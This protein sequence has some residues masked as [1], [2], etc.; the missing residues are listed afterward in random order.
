MVSRAVHL[1]EGADETLP[2]QYT[3]DP[4]PVVARARQHRHRG[5]NGR[6]GR[7]GR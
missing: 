2:H 1:P 4:G 6:A 3:A 7:G 5:Q